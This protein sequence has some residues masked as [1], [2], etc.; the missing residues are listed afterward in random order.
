MSDEPVEV[1]EVRPREYGDAG[2][3]TARS[4]R[5]FVRPGEEDWDEYLDSIADVAGRID[6]TVVLVAVDGARI[7]GSV[8]LEVERTIGDD[9]A[10]LEPGTAH[11]RMLGVDPEARG[12]GIGGALMAACVDL[13]RARGKHTLTLRTTDRMLVAQRMYRAMGFARDPDNDLSFPDLHLLAFRLRLE[14]A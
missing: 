8:T 3:V 12:R 13:A 5:E 14:P 6:R 11:V 2:R 4:Y 7:L 9:D 1:R 10:E